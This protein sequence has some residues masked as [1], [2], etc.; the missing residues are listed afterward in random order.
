MPP[1]ATG[2]LD[3]GGGVEGALAPGL[4]QASSSTV[5]RARIKERNAMGSSPVFAIIERNA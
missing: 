3:I 1:S 2:A 4:S 5:V